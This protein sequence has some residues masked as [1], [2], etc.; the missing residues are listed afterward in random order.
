MAPLLW[1]QPCSW[2]TAWGLNTKPQPCYI[3]LLLH[4]AQEEADHWGHVLGLTFQL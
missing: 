2:S 1:T 4:L 3:W